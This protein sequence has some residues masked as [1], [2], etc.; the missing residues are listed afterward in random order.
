MTVCIVLIIIRLL[1]GHRRGWRRLHT[2][3]SL[4]LLIRWRGISFAAI[5]HRLKVQIHVKF[6]ILKVILA[7]SD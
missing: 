1:I 5:S 6:I 3:R 7:R 4:A 2:R